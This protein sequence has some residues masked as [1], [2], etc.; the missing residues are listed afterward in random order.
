MCVYV[1]FHS[2]QA[3]SISVGVQYDES[4]KLNLIDANILSS[5]CYASNSNMVGDFEVEL[6]GG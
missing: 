4:G 3:L 5:Y 1:T 6:R 2:A